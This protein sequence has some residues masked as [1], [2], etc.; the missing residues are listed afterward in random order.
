M[1][2][3][4][5][6][7][8]HFH[9]AAQNA[10]RHFFFLHIP[11]NGGTSVEL[12]AS[13][14]LS[15]WGLYR[16]CCPKSAIVGTASVRDVCCTKSFASRRS[17]PWHL[18]PDVFF[19]LFHHEIEADALHPGRRL[20]RWCVVR[21]PAERWASEQRWVQRNLQGRYPVV[22]PDGQLQLV[23]QQE[24][25]VLRNALSDGRH[26][27][28]WTEELVHVQPQHWFVWATDGS[29]QCE[30]VVAHERLH[31]FELGRINNSSEAHDDVAVRLPKELKELYAPDVR[32]YASARQS[33]GLCF[34]PRVRRLDRRA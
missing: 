3:T 22:R 33:S 27:V 19:Q 20:K 14:N 11:K 34:H 31:F 4:A 21:D 26:N 13:R 16:G 30:C 18:P 5:A 28:S 10:L 25:T 8:H 15:A 9:H 29:V 7:T 24:A 12:A 1:V 2:L 23:R 6:Q 17:S 32:L